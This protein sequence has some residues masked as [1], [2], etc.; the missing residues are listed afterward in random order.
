MGGAVALLIA[1]CLFSTLFGLGVKYVVD[2][3]ALGHSLAKTL[4]FLL[5]VFFLSLLVKWWPP[6]S[7][8]WSYR[9][10]ALLPVLFVGNL[11]QYLWY[12]R[13]YELNVND[14][15]AVIRDGFW[16]M[17]R[18]DHTHTAKAMLSA[19]PKQLAETTDVGY[20]FGAIFPQPLLWLQLVLFLLTIGACTLSCV[21]WLRNVSSW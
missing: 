15:S 7:A 20:A 18:L 5:F 21:H 16:T 14:W 17:S 8:R 4:L 3:I 11:I 10:A 1:G 19:L 6:V 2:I 12:C 13:S 9:F